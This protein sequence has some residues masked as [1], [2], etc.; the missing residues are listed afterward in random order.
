[1]PDPFPSVEGVLEALRAQE[2]VAERDIGLAVYLATSMRKPLLVEGEPGRGK[3]EI[4]KAV[5]AALHTDLIRLQ[6]YEGLDANA[7]RASRRYRD[8]LQ[9]S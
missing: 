1:M 7:A 5:A 4:A 8:R 3:T 2:Y 9:A 6:C